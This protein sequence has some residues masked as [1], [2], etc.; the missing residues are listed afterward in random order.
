MGHRLS[1]YKRLIE[2][3]GVDLLVFHTKD[4]DQLA[5]HGMAHPLAIELRDVPLLML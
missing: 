1:E 3:H 4:E 2:E 5:M